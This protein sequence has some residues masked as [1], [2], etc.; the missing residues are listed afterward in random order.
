MR[1]RMVTGLCALA[2]ALATGCGDSGTSGTIDQDGSDGLSLDGQGGDAATEDTSTTSD[3]VITGM[4]TSTAADT[5]T[6]PDAQPE[7]DTT[8]PA[9][10]AVAEDTTAPADT[11]G[12][13]DTAV[14]TD[15]TT[16]AACTGECPAA[17]NGSIGVPITLMPGTAQP[18]TLTG[19]ANGSAAPTATYELT[20]VD[21]YRYNALSPL[22]S[23]GIE[24]NYDPNTGRGTNGAT[25][26]GTDLWGVFLNLDISLNLSAV[27]QTFDQ[28]LDQDIYGGGCYA[29][30]GN[31]IVSDLGYCAGGW[32]EGGGRPADRGR[33]QLRRWDLCPE[34]QAHLHEDL[35]P[36]AG[37]GDV[38][39]TGIQ[40][41]P[42]HG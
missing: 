26:F 9:D 14:A 5:A 25:N 40:P 22:I 15:T 34:A 42:H 19:L 10:T 18:P 33:V 11:T 8:A 3:D 4:D 30:S 17:S 6:V 20:A 29:L 38:S 37:P 32:P 28:E 31:T 21:I 35:P 1:V 36:R 24:D 41:Q 13:T 2:L 23:L 7:A 39:G 16:T 12:A 27:G